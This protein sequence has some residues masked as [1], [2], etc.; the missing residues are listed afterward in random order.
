MAACIVPR[1]VLSCT[2]TSDPSPHRKS[3]HI[4]ASKCFT[5]KKGLALLR[6]PLCPLSPA[7]RGLWNSVASAAPSVST[8][9]ALCSSFLSF[10]LFMSHLSRLVFLLLPRLD[11][12][13][14]IPIVVI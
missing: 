8:S 10:S 11:C 5:D 14:L 13:K 1:P 3:L 9:A 6:G 12:Y 4:L 7:W 2:R